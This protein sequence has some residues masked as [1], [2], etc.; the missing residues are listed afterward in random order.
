MSTAPASRQQIG[1][2]HA[3]K[4]RAGLDDD[5]YRDMLR[6]ETGQPSSKGL[7]AGEASRVL[8]YLRAL[9]GRPDM[10]L[11]ACSKGRKA[12]RIDGTY[13]GKLRAL[14]ITGYNLGVVEDRSDKALL[15]F[16]ERQTGIAH[17]NW[18]RD[19]APAQAAIEGLKAW[20]GR[21][22]GVDWSRARSPRALQEAAYHALRRRL[23]EQ[24]V[25]VHMPADTSR[26]ESPQ[27]IEW[28]RAGGEQLRRAMGEQ[29]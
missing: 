9:P 21:E 25:R 11:K 18:W 27:F 6:R 24:R 16:C 19:A 22:A 4:S 14:W 23:I 29:A 20:I 8:D 5:S 17:P 3:A 28:M 13:A 2:I 10:P 15:A 12:I 1:A 26:F 7:N